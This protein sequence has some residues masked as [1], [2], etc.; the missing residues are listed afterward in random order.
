MWFRACGVEGLKWSRAVAG[1]LGFLRI[2]Q[3]RRCVADQPLQGGRS[4]ALCRLP[5]FANPG[6]QEFAVAKEDIKER[7]PSK[8]TL[9]PDQFRNTITQKDFDALLKFLLATKV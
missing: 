2:A 8:Y 9:M 7:V 1:T 4:L 3:G 6:G 5:V